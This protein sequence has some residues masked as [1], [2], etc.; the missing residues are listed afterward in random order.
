MYSFVDVTDLRNAKEELRKYLGKL[1]RIDGK[2]DEIGEGLSQNFELAEKSIDRLSAI[3]SEH[4][5]GA[6]EGEAVR[7]LA[8]TKEAMSRTGSLIDELLKS[9]L[10]LSFYISLINLYQLRIEDFNNS[11]EI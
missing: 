2:T 11:K 7:C 5:A 6:I 3:L 10:P 9:S 8:D 4:Y 1:R